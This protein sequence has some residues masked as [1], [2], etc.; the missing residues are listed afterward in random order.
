[1]I[2]DFQDHASVPIDG[3]SLSEAMHSRY[4]LFLIFFKRINFNI[5]R[6]INI[7]YLGRVAQLLKQQPSLFYLY[8]KIITNLIEYRFMNNIFRIFHLLKYSV[9]LQ[10]IFFVLIFNLYQFIYCHFQSVIF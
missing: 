5:Y 10:N 8:V 7:R 1:M 3:E 4:S 6:G 2:Q 9:E